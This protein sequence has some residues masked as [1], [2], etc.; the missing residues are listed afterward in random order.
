MNRGTR[1]D[2]LVY[3]TQI[4]RESRRKGEHLHLASAVPGG[5]GCSSGWK[6]R[7][8]AAP[9]AEPPGS[10]G[11]QGT[12]ALRGAETG[13]DLQRSL[14]ADG[15]EAHQEPQVDHGNGGRDDGIDLRGA[16]T[17]LVVAAVTYSSVRL[18]AAI[19]W[20]SAKGQLHAIKSG[21][22]IGEQEAVPLAALLK[23]LGGRPVAGPWYFEPVSL[24]HF[25]I[26]TNPQRTLVE[27]ELTF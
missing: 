27:R 19:R 2:C 21:H 9:L 7:E 25:S 16:P 18:S 26:G 22:R 13:V 11:L 3:V 15:L 1:G 10:N 17:K 8:R 12:S 5:S 6:E 20:T 4:V 24:S 23:F 14:S